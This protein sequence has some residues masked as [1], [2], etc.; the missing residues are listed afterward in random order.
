MLFKETKDNIIFGVVFFMLM[1]FAVATYAAEQQT[2]AENAVTFT[3]TI[4]SETKVCQ[5]Q[6][7][8]VEEALKANGIVL[9]EDDWVAPGRKA[10]VA[11]GT[12]IT[13]Y[14][15]EHVEETSTYVAEPEFQVVYDAT[16]E[17]GETKLIYEGVSSEGNMTCW[18]TYKDGVEIGRT[19]ISREVTFEGEAKIVAY[20]ANTTASREGTD[21]QFSEVYEMVATAYTHTGNATKSGV[22]PT[23]GATIAVDP[24]V[25]PL[26]T[27]VYVEGYGFATA[28]DT[29]GVILGNKIDLFMDTEEECIQWGVQTVKMYVLR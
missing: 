3:V 22:M 19:E 11:E 16:M 21:F 15:I 7:V 23:V 26:G 12:E 6:A 17:R 9:G 13:V 5:S 28:E 18:V 10:V 4:D 29:G 2:L 20:G 24:T 8:T 27:E 25:I 1:C 14:R